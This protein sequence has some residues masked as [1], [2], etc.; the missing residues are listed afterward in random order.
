[1]IQ[2]LLRCLF[3]IGFTAV[4]VMPGQAQSSPASLPQ[5]TWDGQSRFTI[6]ILGMDRRPGARDNLNA[7]T[8]VVM[9]AS[10][11]PATRRVGVL[12]IPRDMHFA[13]PGASA[14]VRVNTLMVQGEREAEGYGPQLALETLQYNLGMYIDGYVAFDFI[15]FQ[16]VI[17]AIGGV[18]VSINYIINDPTYPDMNY[19]FDPFYLRAGT[20]QLDGRNALKFARTRHGDNDYLRGQRQLQIVSGVRDR[21]RDP[22]VLQAVV[23]RAPQ[24]FEAL[25]GHVYTNIPPEQL[26]LLGLQ[27][28]QLGDDALAT[29]A[30]NESYSFDYS[31]QGQRVRV[32]DRALLTDLLIMTFGAEYWR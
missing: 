3:L 4:L 15:A 28:M 11:D 25:T 20:H 8:D 1:M 32:P 17:D 26:V 18:T 14:L 23:G 30:I 9:V 27:V 2:W 6:L 12:S 7:R 31:Y 10:Y 22:L 16:Q 29:G 19:G 13:V 21:L 24:L 5:A